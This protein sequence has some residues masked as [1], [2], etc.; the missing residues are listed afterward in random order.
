LRPH[1]HARPIE[2]FHDCARGEPNL[3][4]D[5]CGGQLLIY[6][7]VSRQGEFFLTHLSGLLNLDS[8]VDQVFANRVVVDAKVSSKPFD[9]FHLAVEPN[10]LINLFGP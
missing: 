8:A 5:L 10:D 3:Q 6:I 9:L 4:C 2:R 1:L 7:K